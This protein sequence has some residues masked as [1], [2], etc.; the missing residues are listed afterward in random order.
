MSNLL[1]YREKLNLTQEE[2]AEKSGI[3]VRTIQR[4][5][6]GAN[7]KGHTLNAIAK[8]LDI[9]KEQLTEKDI[10]EKTNF[11]LIK[12]INFS[13]FPFIIIP[14]ANIIV[15]A[16]IM[17]FKKEYNL[18]TKQLITI[19]IMWSLISG[20]LIFLSPF[21]HRVFETQIRLTL[22]VL[23]IAVISNALIII[24]N[25]ISLD[26]HKNIRIKLNFNLI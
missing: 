3:S 11:Q 15:P 18:L 23:I 19:Q 12:L 1:K 13:S 21:F 26:K 17:Y 10:E 20:T 24:L 8:A 14:L 6:A 16:V 2:L 4:I 22:P 9:S 5:E 25:A 7:L